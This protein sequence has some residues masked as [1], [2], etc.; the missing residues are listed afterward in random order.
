LAGLGQLM[1]IV[2]D[3]SIAKER[4]EVFGRQVEVTR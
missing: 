3:R 4:L 2:K 1:F